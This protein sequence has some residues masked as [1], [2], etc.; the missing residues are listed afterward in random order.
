MKR[1]FYTLRIRRPMQ[2]RGLLYLIALKHKDQCEKKGPIG[3][4]LQKNNN[5]EFHN[6]NVK[7]L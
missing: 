5:C 6:L 4:H 2:R 3:K 7:L 1:T